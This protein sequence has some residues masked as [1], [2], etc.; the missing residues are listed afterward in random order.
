MQ[1]H[2]NHRSQTHEHPPT[3]PIPPPPPP[4]RLLLIARWKSRLIHPPSVDARHVYDLAVRPDERI[5]PGRQ[6]RLLAV[7]PIAYCSPEVPPNELDTYDPHVLGWIAETWECADGSL[8]ARVM[9]TCR[10]NVV[11]E[12]ELRFPRAYTT[13]ERDS[14]GTEYADERYGWTSGEDDIE[15]CGQE[16]PRQGESASVWAVYVGTG[17][18]TYR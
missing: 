2:H 16:G 7:S 18:T 14:G 13:S 5:A 15:G 6:V 1:S 4:P 3:A 12:V 9:N 10:K 17:D 8:R 11:R